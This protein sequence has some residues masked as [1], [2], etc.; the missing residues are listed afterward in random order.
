MNIP[1]A[2]VLLSMMLAS[3]QALAEANSLMPV[4]IEVVTTRQRPV[5]GLD[6]VAKQ[7]RTQAIK[8]YYLDDIKRFEDRLSAN[9]PNT[10]AK[11]QT[12]VEARIAE[13]GRQQLE[14][15]LRSAYQA[16][17]LSLHYG[18]DRYP[19]IIF[20]QQCAVLGVTD[21]ARAIQRY[22]QWLAAQTEVPESD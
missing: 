6:P 20:D 7:L 21:I 13:I 5:T 19:A 12:I 14:A 10:P 2:I 1:V 16:V 18:L 4:S 15:D 3:S 22:R 11:A 8:V 9:L 17:G